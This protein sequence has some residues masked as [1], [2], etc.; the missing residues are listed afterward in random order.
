M[1]PPHGI[2]TKDPAAVADAVKRVFATLGAQES[3]LLI[4]RLF[5]DVTRMFWGHYPGFRA[6][7]MQY[8]DFEHTLQATVC[9]VHILE[10]RHHAGA[11]PALSARDMELG[12]I[13]VLLHDC[14]YLKSTD[15]ADGTGAKYTL[16]HVQRSCE[17]ARGYLPPLGIQPDEIED[18]THAISCTG[19]INKFNVIPFRRPEARLIACMLVTADYLGQM[20]ASDYVDELPVLFHEFTEA[21]DHEKLP[22]DK[23]FFKNERQLIEKTPD[24]WE[25]YVRPMLTGDAGAM[26]RFL[27]RPD[28]TNPYLEAVE[29]NIAAVRRLVSHPTPVA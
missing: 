19:P 1:A 18:I 22:D 16:V 14:G 7:D 20:S 15:D 12:L 3:A 21:Y 26:Y 6:I 13:A 27:A 5:T 4:D 10:G 9:L 17:F 25:K 8:H 28:G 24:F 11:S 23:R 29:S 2:N